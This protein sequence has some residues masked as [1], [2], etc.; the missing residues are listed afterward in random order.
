M[1]T[2]KVQNRWVVFLKTG[3]AV[4]LLSA[5]RAQAQTH[6]PSKAVTLLVPFAPGGETDIGSF[7]VAQKLSQ[8][9]G[10]S[11]LV[12]NRAGEAAVLPAP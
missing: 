1:I 7:I 12:D 8:L 10:Q 2:F 11:V 5:N 6:W 3:L 4:L 9:W